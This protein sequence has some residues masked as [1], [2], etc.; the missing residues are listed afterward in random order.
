MNNIEIYQS[1]Y[2]NNE[3]LIDINEK[4]NKN[5]DA[6]VELIVLFFENA[7]LTGGCDTLAT[8]FDKTTKKLYLNYKFYEIKKLILDKKYFNYKEY[9]FVAWNSNASSIDAHKTSLNNVFILHNINTDEDKTVIE[10]Y[11]E[12]LLDSSTENEIIDIQKS[13]LFD[14]TLIIHLKNEFNLSSLRKRL[15]KKPKLRENFIQLYEGYKTNIL[16][17]VLVGCEIDDEIVSD[18]LDDKFN[19]TTKSYWQLLFKTKK[20]NKF[21]IFKF[22][23]ENYLEYC[24]EVKKHL[25]SRD[26]FLIFEKCLNLQFFDSYIDDNF[27]SLN[28]NIDVDED[29]TIGFD[30]EILKKLNITNMSKTSYSSENKPIYNFLMETKSLSTLPLPTPPNI[31]EPVAA[32]AAATSVDPQD[33]DGDDDEKPYYYE[34]DKSD[35]LHD[36]LMNSSKVLQDFAK[37][38]EPGNTVMI[39]D[40]SVYI[41]STNFKI[42]YNE[43][44]DIIDQ[45]IAEFWGKIYISLN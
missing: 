13:S 31:V 38:I 39:E 15:N 1:K 45:K 3:V 42:D 41:N 33:D 35:E 11:V 28:Q 12:Y 32:A 21:I 14:K 7:K 37:F 18:Y 43:W 26:K 2:L 25:I 44:V 24:L 9:S 8:R 5:L 40:G 20:K 29:K 36:I 23:N 30:P 27:R 19:Q 4:L 6:D 10:L 22:D 16:F 34:F 17:G